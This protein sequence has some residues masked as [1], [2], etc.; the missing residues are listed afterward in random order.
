MLPNCS[1]L[2][3]CTPCPYMYVCV[4]IHTY[5]HIYVTICK[6]IKQICVYIYIHIH[7]SMCIYILHAW[8]C[9]H[10]LCIRRG[11]EWT[12]AYIHIYIYIYTH[13]FICTYMYVCMY[14][15]TSVCMYNV[16]KDG[17][18]M[19][20]YET[21][22]VSTVEL[23]ICSYIRRVCSK[24]ET[25]GVISHRITQAIGFRLLSGESAYHKH[26]FKGL[27]RTTC[28]QLLPGLA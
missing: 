13:I 22:H 27:Q 8:I 12:K 14:E 10:F 23:C 18:R 3:P 19:D 6:Q 9:M 5:I 2:Q 26:I 21:E 15:W 4:Y 7:I 24:V 20:L 16:D 11:R 1:R 17:S 25:G 28:T